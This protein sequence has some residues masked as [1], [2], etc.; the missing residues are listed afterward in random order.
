LLRARNSSAV[1]TSQRAPR[2]KLLLNARA[3]DLIKPCMGRRAAYKSGM[4]TAIN[5]TI[6]KAGFPG[7]I[8]HHMGMSFFYEVGYSKV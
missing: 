3:I 8:I 6:D 1:R 4:A 7:Q 2:R 5:S